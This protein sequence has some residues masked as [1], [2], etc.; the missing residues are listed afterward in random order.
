MT[1]QVDLARRNT[2]G[3]LDWSGQSLSHV[4][5]NLY[6]AGVASMERNTRSLF[7]PSEVEVDCIHQL[8][9]VSVF[10]PSR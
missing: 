7:F 5:K 6:E 3:G 9:S 1:T 4:P 10:D 8:T 2:N